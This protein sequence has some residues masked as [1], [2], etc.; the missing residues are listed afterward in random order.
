MPSWMKTAA[1]VQTETREKLASRI[2]DERKKREAEGVTVNGIRYAGDA[3]NRQ[4]LNEALQYADDASLAVFDR[5]KDSDGQYHP[6]HPVSDVRSAL[7]AIAARRNAL[8][9]LE[10]SHVDA[11]MNGAVTDLGDLKWT[12]LNQPEEVNHG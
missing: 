4:A 7:N 8:F 9:S 5:W 12:T 2:P 6:D 10:A 1:E 3:G 11:V